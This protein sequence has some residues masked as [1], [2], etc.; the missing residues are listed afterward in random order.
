V[1]CF[2]CRVS[3]APYLVHARFIVWSAPDVLRV[4]TEVVKRREE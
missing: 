3:G 4:F 1:N 2:V